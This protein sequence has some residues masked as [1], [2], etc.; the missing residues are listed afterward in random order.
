MDKSK[1]NLLTVAVKSVLEAGFSVLS[2]Y[3][4]CR[5]SVYEKEDRSPL[6]EADLLSHRVIC[7]FL[8]GTGYPVL[9]EEGGT[10]PYEERKS[11]KRFWL[12]DPL[13]GTKEFINRNG[14]FTVNVALIEGTR[15]V[16]GVV[17]APVL[18]DLY[19]AAEGIGAYKFNVF[20][21]QFQGFSLERL[22]KL[23]VRL[24]GMRGSNSEEV[25]VVTSRSH[26]S[27]RTE[28]FV[29]KLRE[30][31]CNVKLVSK[32]SSLKLCLIAEGSADIYPRLSP[33]M[34]WDTAAGQAIVEISGGRV[35]NA[36]TGETLNYNKRE[37]LNPP[38]IAVKKGYEL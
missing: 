35:V 27:K 36:E 14:E 20:E 33:T 22:V 18:G 21:K 17:Y 5:F 26:M 38:F 4:A 37:L 19:F 1:E 16:L 15:P 8:F 29:G 34:E 9:S 10:V 31:G 2:I 12:V 24:R 11:W 13:D 6:T 23:S 3:D 7:S 32:G 25:I 30:S 28:E